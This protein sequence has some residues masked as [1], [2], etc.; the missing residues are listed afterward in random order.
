MKNML[1]REIVIC[2]H[3]I[4][5]KVEDGKLVSKNLHNLFSDL[6]DSQRIGKARFAKQELYDRSLKCRRLMANG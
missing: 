2:Y 4:N 1:W 3:Y 5:D 6:D